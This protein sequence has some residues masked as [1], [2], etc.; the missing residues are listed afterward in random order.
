MQI[1]K[2]PAS[3]YMTPVFYWMGFVLFNLILE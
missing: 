2:Q 1:K 3:P